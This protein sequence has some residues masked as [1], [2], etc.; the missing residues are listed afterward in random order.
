M[1]KEKLFTPDPTSVGK[2]DL[3]K[4]FFAITEIPRIYDFHLAAYAQSMVAQHFI[5]ATAGHVD[6]GK[7]ALVKALTGTDPDRLPEEK[8][9]GITIDLGFAHLELPLSSPADDDMTMASIGLV[10]VPGHEDFVKNMVA[11]VGSID[12]ALLVIAADDGWMPQTEEHFQILEYLG[13][14]QAVIALTKVDLI[15]DQKAEVIAKVREQLCGSAFETAPIVGTSVITGEGLEPLKSALA[16]VLARVKPSPDIGKPRLPIDR[17]FTL[18]GIGTVVTGTLNGGTLRRNQGVVLQ[19]SGRLARVRNLQSHNSDAD[20]IGPGTRAALNLPDLG[21][22]TDD[23]TAAR[24]GEVVTVEDLGN[25]CDTISVLLVKSARLRGL[26]QTGTA[27]HPLKDGLLVRM[28]HGSRNVPARVLLLDPHPLVPGGSVVAQLRFKQPVFVLGGDRF[29]LRDGGQQFTIAGGTVLD[30]DARRER[31]RSPEERAFLEQR[32]VAPLNLGVWITTQ[33]QHDH[34][35]DRSRL[36]MKTNYAAVEISRMVDLLVARE[37]AV[38]A[39]EWLVDAE[40]WREAREK[41]AGA[42]HAAN[43]ENPE[44]G[45]LELAELRVQLGSISPMPAIFDMLLAS[46]CAGEFVQLGTA[47]SHRSHRPA[48]PMKLQAAGATV[49][50]KLAAKPLEPPARIELAPDLLSQQALRF[51][52]ETGEAMEISGELVMQSISYEHARAEII[53]FLRAHGPATAGDV[54]QHL[55]TNRRVIIPLLEKLDREG[56]TRRE[57]DLRTAR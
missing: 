50:A 47:V 37:K 19:P 38:A 35:V 27:A 57:G 11:G 36:L 32:S 52:I 39:G 25:P 55:K 7:S 33:L 14:S 26:K 4:L 54:R 22:S 48:L 53:K 24:R 18:R 45:G 46:L 17:V 41:A 34:A 43:R 49:R 3:E 12:L 42:I 51:L 1:V 31:F 20:H 30:A 44:K 23:D 40:W 2:L 8:S 9:R 29:I 5:V 10:D 21:S 15:G 13:V 6:H 16:R 28:H 56:I